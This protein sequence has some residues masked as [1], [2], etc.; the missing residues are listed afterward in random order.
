MCQS[1]GTRVIITPPEKSEQEF[2]E[3]DY[4]SEENTWFLQN[5]REAAFIR[6]SQILKI[7]DTG[8]H[9]FLDIGSATGHLFKFYPF[10]KMRRVTAIEPS[11][12]GVRMI[13]DRYPFVEAVQTDIDNIDFSA[14]SFDAVALLDTLIYHK[15][16]RA[17]LA[18]I[19]RW[20]APDGIF[21]CEVANYTWLNLVGRVKTSNTYWKSYYDR[22]AFLNVLKENSFKPIAV[23]NNV[24]S[25]P[26][27]LKGI[28][29]KVVYTAT[30]ALHRITFGQLDIVPKIIVAARS[31]PQG[32]L[33]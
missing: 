13:K 28:V 29:K 2:F 12:F 22:R 20:L 26:S 23:Y 5:Y 27:G 15:E 9:T 32:V 18:R 6:I 4:I 16:P 3:D 7:H 10:E 24:G 21:I 17:L 14:K 8:W 33:A 1:C 25:V 11:R 31:V 30:F 19:H